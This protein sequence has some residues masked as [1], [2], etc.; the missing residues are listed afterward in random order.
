L[1]NVALY[2]ID[3]TGFPNLALMK[4]GTFLK[5]EGYLPILNPPPGLTSLERSYASIVF[6]YNNKK[7]NPKIPS[8][9][10]GG[11]GIDLKKKLP[12]HIEKLIPDYSLYGI[13]Y[14]FGFL[15][16]GCIR[17]CKF[18]IV[19]KKEGALRQV[20]E[21]GDLLNPLSK[22]IILLDNNFLG[23]PNHIQ[24]LKDIKKLGLRVDFNQG[25]DIRLLTMGVGDILRQIPPIR[26]WR[27]SFDTISYVEETIKGISILKQCGILGKTQFFVLLGYKADLLETKERLSIV[28]KY[29]LN[30][31]FM[32]YCD[33]EGNV[34][35]P[36]N[37]W[38]P[39]KQELID[40]LLRIRSPI[41]N[42]K[43]ILRWLAG[44]HLPYSERRGWEKQKGGL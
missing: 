19:R 35:A 24:L 14:G 15:S 3:K 29:K 40:L 16:R 37:E 8:D 43:K 2:D 17:N 6:T 22:D 20:S 10:V 1:I 33:R 9:N 31:F 28:S 26:D 38:E 44:G 41:G 12:P 7:V 23:L 36:P 18:C 39:H 27:F 5:S 32:L 11:S 21:I 30:C 25:L 13:K 4:L 42:K 34:P